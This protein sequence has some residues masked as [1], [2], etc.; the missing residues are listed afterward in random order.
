MRKDKIIIIS[1]LDGT[2]ERKPFG[3]I[4]QLIPLAD[5]VIKLCAICMRCGDDAPFTHRLGKYYIKPEI[6]LSIVSSKEVELVG[7]KDIYEP[8]CRHCYYKCTHHH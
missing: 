7:W 1:A 4:P 2:F 8:L 3:Q 6:T 5:E